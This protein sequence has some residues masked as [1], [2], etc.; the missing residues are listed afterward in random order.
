MLSVPVLATDKTLLDPQAKWVRDRHS[1]TW[2]CLLSTA[3][4][5]GTGMGA[6]AIAFGCYLFVNL[7][8]VA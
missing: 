3:V 1:R 6:F 4:A 2:A 5:A 7:P 8:A